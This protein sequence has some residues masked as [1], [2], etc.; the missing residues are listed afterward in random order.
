MYVSTSATSNAQTIR[1]TW[2]WGTRNTSP[3]IQRPSIVGTL[4]VR[5]LHTRARNVPVCPRRTRLPHTHARNVPVCP[6][7]TRLLH[8]HAR[9]APVFFQTSQVHQ[10]NGRQRE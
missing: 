3:R 2:R 5:V 8:T 6:R 10:D 4:L 1:P 7:R 9:N